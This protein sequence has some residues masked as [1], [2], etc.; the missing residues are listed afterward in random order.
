MV[1]GSGWL[2]DIRLVNDSDLLSSGKISVLEGVFGHLERPSSSNNLQT[3]ENAWV[4]LMLD[5]R[6]LALQ[7]VPNDDN[8]NVLVSG[9]D[10]SE[11]LAVND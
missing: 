5:S 6:V 1:L 10:V 11:V 3:L 9:G 7:V 2:H 4:D 8:I